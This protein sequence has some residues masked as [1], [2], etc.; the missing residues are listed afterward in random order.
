MEQDNNMARL[1]KAITAKDFLRHARRTSFQHAAP[2]VEDRWGFND[3][4][5]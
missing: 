2:N 3:I 1:Q 5:E 4:S